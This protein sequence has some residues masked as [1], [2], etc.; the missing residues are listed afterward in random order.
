MLTIRRTPDTFV[1]E[2]D[3]MGTRL[4]I[5]ASAPR[6]DRRLDAR[7]VLPAIERGPG[8]G[9][10]YAKPGR[11]EARMDTTRLASGGTFDVIRLL[12]VPVVRPD[13]TREQI[14]SLLIHPANW[15]RQLTGCIAPGLRRGPD[16][17]WH[18]RRAM[19][20]IFAVLGGFKRGRPVTVDVEELQAM[21]A[22]T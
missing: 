11:Y 18:S 14:N 10:V 4:Y 5:V 7:L 6:G 12:S 1:D 22:R 9:F 21:E 15:P 16:A 17:V 19:D 20:A 3:A 13:G 2:T 8:S